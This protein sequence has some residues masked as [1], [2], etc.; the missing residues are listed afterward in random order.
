MWNDCYNITANEL[1]RIMEATRNGYDCVKYEPDETL[2]IVLEKEDENG[3]V[4]DTI[5][6]EFAPILI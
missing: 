4:I 6:F 3:D 2:Y 1:Q 5:T